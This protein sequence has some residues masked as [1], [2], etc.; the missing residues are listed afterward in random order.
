MGSGE[1][2]V[3]GRRAGGEWRTV[4]TSCGR[5][6]RASVKSL[7][8][9]VRDVEIWEGVKFWS[10]LLCVADDIVEDELIDSESVSV[11]ESWPRR[12]FHL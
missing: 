12:K 7:W 4:D 3:S 11:V 10:G 2:G 5:N 6:S 8:A 9:E 1:S